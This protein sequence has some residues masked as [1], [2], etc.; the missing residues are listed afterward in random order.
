MTE[1]IEMASGDISVW[2][3]GGIHVDVN[4]K[5]KDPIEPGEQEA[6]RPGELLIRLTNEQSGKRPEADFQRQ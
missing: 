1:V 6:L 2:V 4:T 5:S 3:D